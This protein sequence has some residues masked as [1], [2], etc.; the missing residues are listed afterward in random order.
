MKKIIQGF[1]ERYFVYFL[2][3][4]AIS[5][6]VSISAST[7]ILF[8][9]FLF[10]IMDIKNNLKNSPRDFLLFILFYFWRI[11]SS[12]INGFFFI[13]IKNFFNDIWDK[14]PYLFCS[15][16]K[17]KKEIIISFLNILLY[18]NAFILFY[19][20]FER[21]LGLPPLFKDL[22]TSDM[23]RFKGYHS[24]PLRFAGYYSSI[25]LIAFSFGFFYSR[26][27]IY[28]FLFL[29]FGLLLNGSRSY[30]FSVIITIMIISL[31]KSKR[32]F[33]FTISGIIIY[34]LLFFSLF[35]THTMRIK[36][37]LSNHPE[38][39]STTTYKNLS[40]MELRKNFWIAGIEIFLKSPVYGIGEKV[41]SHLK[42]YMEKNLID[43]TAHCHNIYITM[44]A[45][46]GIIGCGLLIWILL[47]F[48]IKYFKYYKGTQDDFSKAF[49]I[50]LFAIFLN[51]SLAGFTEHNL[52]TFVLWGFVSLYAGLF[53]SYR[54]YKFSE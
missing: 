41:S 48:I 18:V 54:L 14:S 8:I 17:I 24:H 3:L 32:F 15:N 13:S 11:V 1:K 37:I 47:Y 21:F 27:Y 28:L 29:L 35:K 22:F 45:E 53:E 36:N 6:A 10:Y 19:A 43:N 23:M 50:S 49:S 44:M 46:N 52:S 16:L 20:L 51:I 26:K 4:F 34:F 40:D 42:P 33:V 9:F 5:S 31:I 39:V 2:Y 38:N 12:F 7:I 25:C 30:W